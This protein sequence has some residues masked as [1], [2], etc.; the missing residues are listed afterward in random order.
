MTA[1]PAEHEGRETELLLQGVTVSYGE[2]VA[3]S[4]VNLDVAAEAVVAVIGP[5]GCGKSTM[6]RAIAGLEPLTE[7]EIELGGRSLRGVPT[8]QR[9]LGLMFQEHALFPHRSVAGN[10]AFG[11]E[12]KGRTESEIRERVGEV[13]ELVGMDGFGS[14]SIE[15]LSGGE[16]QRVALARALAP[17]PRL[18]MLDEP[19]GSLDRVLRQQLTGDLREVFARTG[20]TAIHVTHD[21]SEAFALA[22]HVVILRAG[23]IEQQGS[24]ADLWRHPTSRFVAEFLGHPNVWEVDGRHV[25]TPVT[26]LQPDP[27]GSIVVRVDRVEFQEGRFR[28]TGAEALLVS[29]RVVVFDSDTA[30]AVGDHLRLALDKSQVY[31]LAD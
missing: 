10:V 15:A 23:R 24:P 25:L 17:T 19:L 1:E 12:R 7:G 4:A 22:D 14:R 21:Q 11:L 2:K 9:D 26:A 3:L 18:L 8:H 16:A 29:E 6:L 28:I 27:N 30:P 13:L 31:P 20:V 5:S